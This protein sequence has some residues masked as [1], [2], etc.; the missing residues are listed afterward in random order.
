MK[1]TKPKVVIMSNA[2]LKLSKIELTDTSKWEKIDKYIRYPGIAKF[3]NDITKYEVDKLIK[4]LEG[5]KTSD[6]LMIVD[7]ICT[8]IK[9]NY[10]KATF[11]TKKIES[12]I[13]ELKTKELDNISILQGVREWFS[14]CELL[15]VDL[16][17]QE[18]LKFV[19]NR[20]VYYLSTYYLFGYRRTDL[21]PFND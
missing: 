20:Q 2:V 14:M 17:S 7:S 3:Y 9:E 10:G 8:L 4:N 13:T 21:Q 12:L 16:V 15:D 6:L 1:R 19:H 18:I 11:V 5:L